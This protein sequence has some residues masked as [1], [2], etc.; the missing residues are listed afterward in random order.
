VQLN[1]TVPGGSY[2]W[3]DG[4]TAATYNVATG[5]AY[6]VTVTANNCSATDAVQVSFN[7]FPVVQLGNDT[8]LCAG[9]SVLLN[10]T[11]P[12]ATYLWQNGATT[13]TLTASTAGVYD[14]D[15]TLNGCT[16]TDAITVGVDP[17]PVVQLGNDTTICAGQPLTLN[18]TY[19]G[20]TYL[21]QDGSTAATINAA[22]GGLFSVTLD[23]N[24]CTASD[25]RTVSVNPLPAFDLGNDTIV[26]PGQSV[27]F[28]ASVPGATYLWHDGSTNA[29]WTA[30]S[31]IAASVTVTLNGCSTTDAV[32]VATFNLQVVDLG[33]DVQVCAGTPVPLGVALPGAS[34]LWSTG[35]TSA[36]V[37]A[38]ASGTYWVRTTLNGCQVSDT[39]Q[40]TFIPLP[41]VQL[42]N[43]TMVCPGA[44]MPLDATTP[45]GSY[46]W[47][48][49][50]T[51][52]TVNAGA[53]NWSVQV[54][55]NGCAGTDAITI[56]TW[57]PPSVAL[58]NDTTL[59][60][61]ASLN[62]N[63]SMPGVSYLWQNGSNSS[64]F[65]VTT[66]GN[67]SVTVTDGNGCTGSDAVIVTYANPQAVDLGN[68]TTICAGTGLVLDATVTGATYAWSTGAT[69]ATIT[70]S[71]AGTYSVSLLQGT[72][73]VND[74]IT[75]SVT[76][77]PVVDLGNDT[78]LCPGATLL[79]DASVP[80][81]SY[82]WQ[83]ASTAGTFTVAAAGTFTVTV[84]N[85]NGC[86]ATDAID[87][88]YASPN[89]VALGPDQVLCQGA[90]AV[91][92]ATLPGSTYLWN[93]GA[94]TATI[95][96]GSTGTY[97]V[98]VLQGAC[99]VSD[100]VEI[101]VLPVPVVDLG[102]DTTLC[103]GASIVLDASWPGA[104][105]LWSTGTTASTTTVT[106]SST[107]WATATLNGCTANDTVNVTVLNALVLDLGNDTTLCPGASV[108][109]TAQLPG[110]TTTWST[111]TQG[112]A[113]TV[114]AA[115]TYWAEVNVGGCSVSDTLVVDYNPLVPFDLGPDADLCAG[116]TMVLDATSTPGSSYLWDD[117][118]TSATRTVST[119]GTF[120]ASASL[121]GCTT[122][123]SITITLIP[124]PVVDLGAD[125]SL[126]PG[127][128][129][130]L[131]A[132]TTGANYLWSTGATTATVIATPGNWSVTVT[133]NGCS[134][135]DAIS[136]GTLAA[137]LAD[138]G[139]DTTL[140]DGAVLVLDAGQPGATYLWQNGAT[141]PTII[142]PQAGTY[143][144]TVELNGCTAS[145]QVNVA[146]FT[147]A[148]VDLGQDTAL[149]PGTT[150]GWSFNLP[151]ASYLWS[152]GST[153][154]QFTT[155]TAGTVWLMAGAPG[156]MGTDTVV[157]SVVPLP[158]PGLGDD[159]TGCAGDTV[160]L[161][162]MPGNAQV[163][164]SS[165]STA[166]SIAVTTGGTYTVSLTLD[167]CTAVDDVD[168]VL[169][170][171]VVAVDLPGEATL[172]LGEELV[173]DATV[174]NGLHLWSTG[175]TDARIVV[176]Q[177]G[178]YVVA[179]TGPCINVLDTVVVSEGG[180]APFVHVPNAFTPNGDGFNEAFVPVVDGV[181]ESFELQV[182][183][184][185]GER[186]F[187]TAS[188][189][190]AWDGTANGTPVQDGV[191]VWVLR[192]KALSV[193]GVVQERLTGHVTLL[194]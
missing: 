142:V 69:T 126:C 42:G 4:S 22:G 27:T 76:S 161:S 29:T 32:N 102:N 112:P 94:T 136:I 174:P 162:V 167:G 55:L 77:A 23:L 81:A 177:P 101:T 172:C 26:C 119:G 110:G 74:A 121:G 115:G 93:T 156:C 122:A 39:V 104:T 96:V 10:A 85:V 139:N 191:Y 7:P 173:L 53:G 13:P 66:A 160:Q 124:L 68:D 2:L 61:G 43:N 21:W 58:G 78:T 60:P 72:C 71:A 170:P 17:L 89:A 192:Y 182:F 171:V 117:G 190:E 158:Q 138:L 133:V 86:S 159:V 63:A 185:W 65:L 120:W 187:I 127:A 123:D 67:Y 108:V 128:S 62:L 80:G 6:S 146:Y 35:A 111:G 157:V 57:T 1:A 107:V 168:V 19:P 5:G 49:G 64:S 73:T 3:Q 44:T 37:N 169:L 91:L 34:Y 41:V 16:T 148:S 51:T 50:A 163:L 145:D 98:Q 36:M 118:S 144:V 20:A 15:V 129:L 84:T 105:Y 24:G 166:G 186:I 88:V 83:D 132:T 92:D 149:C 116:N 175:D 87:V 11:V 135:S 189:G 131:D 152:D 95:T 12:G 33:P 48:N 178:I 155:G 176:Q 70:A 181:F 28:D 183:D 103:P 154:A 114:Q 30:S 184:R 130:L 147:P 9:Q 8:T 14:V 100:T 45:G 140:C 193:D 99:S 46:L 179:V 52:A 109:L 90:S 141:T 188:P 164:W 47:S 143:G 134:G 137:P 75:V 97:A 180:C 38:T 25:S 194:R 18:A 151:S 79:L 125:T 150:V 40:V 113:I 165:G 106:S 31:A 54:T 56:G 82:L 59:C 153:S